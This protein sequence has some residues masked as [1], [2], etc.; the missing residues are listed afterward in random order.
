[1]VRYDPNGQ[2]P[3]NIIKDN[4]LPLSVGNK[5]LYKGGSWSPPYSSNYIKYSEATSEQIIGERRYVY[6]TGLGWMSYTDKDKIFFYYDNGIEYPYMD[7]NLPDFTLYPIKS[8]QNPGELFYNKTHSGNVYQTNIH[9]KGYSFPYFE[10]EVSHTFA[11]N[12]GYYS[13]SDDGP[14]YGNSGYY[15]IQALIKDSTGTLQLY[16]YPHNP[17]IIFT[18]ITKTADSLLT[19]TLTVNHYFSVDTSSYVLQG[20]NFID[21]VSMSGFYSSANDTLPFNTVYGENIYG[22]KKF[23]FN[24]PIDINLLS[25]NYKLNYWITAQ[26]KG[27]VPHS[28]YKPSDSTYYQMILDTTVSVDDQIN[29][30]TSFQLYQNYPNPFNPITTIKYEIPKEGL[31]SLKVYDILGSEIATLVNEEK[32]VGRYEVNFNASSLS[33]GVYLYRIQV[34]DFINV[35]KMILMK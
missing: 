6:V 18:P 21:T 9:S 30:L 8:S 10:G 33:S 31:V 15:L 32:S 2:L 35:K 23:S 4:Y 14:L 27:I 22:T 25:S 20:L 5:W 16:D 11:E 12:L 26:D 28:D 3:P 24:V 19:F 17:Q 1:M 7:F 34:N 29:L 13:Y